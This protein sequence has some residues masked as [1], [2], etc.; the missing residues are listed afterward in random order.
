MM[1]Q[2]L[3]VLQRRSVNLPRLDRLSL[4]L[5]GAFL[6]VCAMGCQSRRMQADSD[7]PNVSYA[8]AAAP[9]QNTLSRN[10]RLA[11]NS[12]GPVEQAEPSAGSGDEESEKQVPRRNGLFPPEDDFQSDAKP[13]SRNE[14]NQSAERTRRT[15]TLPLFRRKSVA[16]GQPASAANSRKP[17]GPMAVTQ[18]P[19]ESRDRFSYAAIASV[20]PAHAGLSRATDQTAAEAWP[21]R[22]VLPS[23]RDRASEAIEPGREP[24]RLDDPPRLQMTPTNS[25]YDVSADVGRG[26]AIPR[27]V[28]CRQV[29]GYEDVVPLDARRLRQGQPLL[30][31]VTLENFRSMPTPKGYRTLT[32]STLEIRSR[33][34]EVLQRQSLGTAVDLVDVPRRDFYL[35]H[36]I[37]IPDNLPAGDYF[38]DLYVDDLLKHESAQARVT[39]GVMEDRNRR[40]GMAG[41][42]RSATRPAGFR[43]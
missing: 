33:D 31:Y 19:A 23:D 11:A 20:D 8:G 22:R 40:D 21:V 5:T 37:T 34:G 17:A 24:I 27:I 14:G 43:K 10:S 42:S 13:L 25:V 15:L 30:I 36:L 1:M 38:F 32:L 2:L 18:T 29:R 9:A 39:V 6:A 12:T 35:T 28:I 26:L 4:L 16:A 41:I 3:P 7:H